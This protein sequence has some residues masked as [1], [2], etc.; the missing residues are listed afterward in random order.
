MPDF[1]SH[2]AFEIARRLELR[3]TPSFAWIVVI[4][5]EIVGDQIQEF[6]KEVKLVL[7]ASTRIFNAF[8]FD[9]DNL[10]NAVHAP[11]HDVLVVVGLEHLGKDEW[12]VLDVNRSALERPGPLILWLPISSVGALNANAPNIRSFIGGSI[13]ALSDEGSFMTEQERANRIEEL[14][15]S[16]NLSS[17][18]VVEMAQR[19]TLPAEPDFAEWLV[20]LGRGD[21]L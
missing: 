15:A 14:S 3:G 11:N 4:S 13:F 16:Y 7:D 5:P 17:K 9:F 19:G 1:S 8:P 6:T 2:P 21:L 20:L 12:G 10:R 18:A